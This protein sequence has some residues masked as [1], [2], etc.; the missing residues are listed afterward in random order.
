MNVCCVCLEPSIIKC[1][2][3]N[4][5]NYCSVNCQRNNKQKHD[6]YCNYKRRLD[7]AVESELYNEALVLYE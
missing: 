4:D 2:I 3:C 7:T 1:N 6:N 5:E